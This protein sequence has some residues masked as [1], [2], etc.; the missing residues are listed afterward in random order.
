VQVQVQEYKYSST[1]GTSVQFSSASSRVLD[2]GV[3]MVKKFDP[4]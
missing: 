1:V 3:M 2:L 4:I